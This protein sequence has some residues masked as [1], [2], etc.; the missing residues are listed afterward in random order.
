MRLALLSGAVA[1]GAL[2]AR[3]HG[4]SSSMHIRLVGAEPGVSDSVSVPPK[5]L[6]L[7]FSDPP[8]LVFTEAEVTNSAGHQIAIDSVLKKG[9]K[10]VVLSLTSAA[11]TSRYTVSWKTAAKDGHQESGSYW[12]VV[13]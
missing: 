5:A 6:T 11:P 7:R 9:D 3:P 1:L 13:R 2:A 10:A 12:F 4:V 8:E